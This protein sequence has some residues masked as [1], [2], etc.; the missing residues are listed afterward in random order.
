MPP[1]SRARSYQGSPP[2][3]LRRSLRTRLSRRLRSTDFWFRVFL[4]GLAFG[5]VAGV[6]KLVTDVEEG[7]GPLPNRQPKPI[8]A[9]GISR[10]L[11]PAEVTHTV[12]L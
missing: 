5:L 2:P 4:L 12:V 1:P 9:P 6:L 8:K 7:G 10:A 11:T 3:H